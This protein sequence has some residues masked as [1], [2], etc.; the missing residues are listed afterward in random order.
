VV[1]V[2]MRLPPWQRTSTCLAR[3]GPRRTSRTSMVTSSSPNACGSA[4]S[5]AASN[6]RSTSAPSVMSPL[7]P[8]NGSM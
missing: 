8:E 6:P 4:A 7:M 2:A 3:K 5:S 1:K